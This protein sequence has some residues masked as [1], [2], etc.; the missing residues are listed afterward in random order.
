MTEEVR[1]GN[2]YSH[3]SLVYMSTHP[4]MGAATHILR[5]WIL[6]SVSGLRRARARGRRG[7]VGGDSRRLL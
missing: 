6:P 4:S 7:R 1:Q 5:R 3:T 2:V